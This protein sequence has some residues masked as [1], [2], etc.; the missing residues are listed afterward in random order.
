MNYKFDGSKVNFLHLI[1]TFIT[2]ISFV[3]CNRPFEDV[4]MM[5]E[6]LSP[7]GIIQLAWMILIFSLG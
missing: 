7:I 1:P 4:E 6:R 2:E 5:N 3:F